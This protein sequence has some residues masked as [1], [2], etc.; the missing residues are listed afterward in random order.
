MLLEGDYK[1][2]L[3][4]EGQVCWADEVMRG[5]CECSSPSPKALAPSRGETGVPDPD[6]H[7]GKNV[8]QYS[9]HQ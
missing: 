5:R 9:M 3:E 1:K 4:N 8:M 6:T 2:G 7:P